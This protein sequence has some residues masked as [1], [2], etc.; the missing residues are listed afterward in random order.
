ME[1]QHFRSQDYY[2]RHYSLVDVVREWELAGLE[3]EMYL[4]LLEDLLL[5]KFPEYTKNIKRRIE[6]YGKKANT[7]LLEYV[8]NLIGIERFF[9]DVLRGRAAASTK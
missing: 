8:Q 1:E 3:L 9:Y 5:L 4:P 2:E 6:F 7:N